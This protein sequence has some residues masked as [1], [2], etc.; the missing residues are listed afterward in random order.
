M[1]KLRNEQ[2]ENFSIAMEH[3]RYSPAQQYYGTKILFVIKGT[4]FVTYEGSEEELKEN[5]ILFVNRNSRY[6]VVGD[7]ESLLISLSISSHFFA[8]YYKNY[9]HCY[10]QNFSNEVN[11]GRE[12]VMQQMRHLL[13][14]MIIEKYRDE[15]G[16][17]LVI[18]SSVYQIMLMMTR[19]FK[20]DVPLWEGTEVNDER[21]VRIIQM[22]EQ[23]YD[24]PLTLSEV[25]E[26]EYLSPSYLSRY[27]KQMTGV[28]FL[29]YLYRVRL[30]HSMEDLL[31]TTDNLFQIAM[32]N[33]FSTAK[34]YSAIFKS[35]HNQTPSEYRKEHQQDVLPKQ[36]TPEE[37]VEVKS[38]MESPAVLVQLAK[39]LDEGSEKNFIYDKAPVEERE[40]TVNK[41]IEETLGNEQHL[42]FVGQLKSL[43]DKNIQQQVV[44]ANQELGVAF[45]V[46]AFLSVFFTTPRDNPNAV[47][48]VH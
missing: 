10:F 8:L 5:D 16:S 31:Y 18:Q 41:E 25:A 48:A 34:N 4:V 43:L 7:E 13:S 24:E 3:I 11:S 23:R 12:G 36:R 39:Y 35:I 30:K 1:K 47:K 32:K 29:H 27:F 44:T 14:E 33:G 28:G 2:T 6:S 20:K 26:S 42:V 21:I 40:I 46:I 45:V 17:S 22:I 15:D 37:E 19:F 9:F 38:V